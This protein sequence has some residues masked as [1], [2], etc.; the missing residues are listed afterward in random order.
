MVGMA[1]GDDAD[2]TSMMSKIGMTK[3]Y[4]LVGMTSGYDKLGMTKGMIS[5]I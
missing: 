3:M 4:D 5:Q 1:L 2:E